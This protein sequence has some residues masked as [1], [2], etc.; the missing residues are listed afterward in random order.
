MNFSR[1]YY[2]A[3]KAYYRRQTPK[4]SSL[5]LL[6]TK[7]ENCLPW[8]LGWICS[9]LWIKWCCCWRRSYIPWHFELKHM[10]RMFLQSWYWYAHDVDVFSIISL[11]RGLHSPKSGTGCMRGGGAGCWM[12]TIV[13]LVA[14]WDAVERFAGTCRRSDPED[15]HS[16]GWW[17]N[18]AMLNVPWWV[19]SLADSHWQ[20]HV[21]LLRWI[22]LN[23]VRV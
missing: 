19:R 2:I 9:N 15:N 4:I 6:N 1:I 5:T 20:R 11:P 3:D 8:S 17:S 10:P 12:I 23:S 18:I 14:W 13:W 16:Q 21:V 22:V 7:I